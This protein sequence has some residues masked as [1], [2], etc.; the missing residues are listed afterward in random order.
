[1]NSHNMIQKN[2][3]RGFT[4][5]ELLVVIAILAVL[6]VAVVLVL[7]PAELLKQGRDTTRI[8]DLAAMNSAIALY[9]AD[10][11]T[12]SWTTVAGSSPRCTGATPFTGGGGSITCTVNA[13]TTVD[14][15]GW[16]PVNFQSISSGAP[17]SRLPLDPVNTDANEYLYAAS[18]TT[19]YFELVAKMESTK[20]KSGGT[21]DVESNSKDG[22]VG[23]NSDKVY[24]VGSELDLI[25]AF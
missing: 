10:V 3:K 1:M 24:Q 13:T 23:T 19:G 9:I 12:P 6:A 14:G 17:L 2:A 7:N 5:I 8:S 15:N 4:L 22:G 25:S 20:Y 16:V 11:R 18:S 21:A